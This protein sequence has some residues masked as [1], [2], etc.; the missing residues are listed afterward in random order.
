MAASA[1]RLLNEGNNGLREAPPQVTQC[2]NEYAM[3]LRGVG[4]CW[5]DYTLPDFQKLFGDLLSTKSLILEAYESCK[6]L[7]KTDL[8]EA[9]EDFLGPEGMNCVQ[10]AQYALEDAESVIQSIEAGDIQEASKEL[11]S[12]VEDSQ[13]ALK[14]CEAFI[15]QKEGIEE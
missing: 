2:F 10:M 13:N 9:V 8:I 1:S 15:K 11:Y 14:V 3:A 12:L 6:A 5:T 7:T 4:E